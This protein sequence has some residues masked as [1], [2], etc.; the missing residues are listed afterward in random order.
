MMNYLSLELLEKN[1]DKVPYVELCNK[2]PDGFDEKFYKDFIRFMTSPEDEL[3]DIPS[4]E[5][6][7]FLE[8]GEDLFVTLYLEDQPMSG[9]F[10]RLNTATSSAIA[11][12]RR[13]L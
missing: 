11:R 10:S 4:E 2:I 9:I 8:R 5:I 1:L 3:D 13:I 6:V 7:E 12:K